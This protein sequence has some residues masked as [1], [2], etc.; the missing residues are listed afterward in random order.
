[1]IFDGWRE[2][3]EA[4]AKAAKPYERDSSGDRPAAEPGGMECEEC[5]RIFIGAE[6]H[7]LCAVCLR[8]HFR[9]SARW[10]RQPLGRIGWIAVVLVTAAA[11]IVGMW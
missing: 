11:V 9:A 4:G 2:D 10:F 7:A 5:G 8:R 1:M 6:W 3:W